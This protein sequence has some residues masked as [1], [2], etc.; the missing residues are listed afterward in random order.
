[1]KC[2]AS[3]MCAKGIDNEHLSVGTSGFV[4]WFIKYQA[5]IMPHFVLSPVASKLRSY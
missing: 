4:I 5:Y 3:Q 2:T 1:M